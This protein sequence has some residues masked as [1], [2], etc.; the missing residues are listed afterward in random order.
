MMPIKEGNFLKPKNYDVPSL[1]VTSYFP[2]E[3]RI[4]KKKNKEGR[5]IFHISKS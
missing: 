1:L 3:Q 2:E 4:V 5:T